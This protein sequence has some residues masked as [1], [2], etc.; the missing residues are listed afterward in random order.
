MVSQRQF[1]A[2]FVYLFVLA[3]GLFLYQYAFFA[4]TVQANPA[5]VIIFLLY[6][7]GPLVYFLLGAFRRYF[8]WFFYKKHDV[9]VEVKN[10]ML[11]Y[12]T[13]LVLTV[14]TQQVLNH[15]LF[16]ITLALIVPLGAALAAFLVELVLYIQEEEEHKYH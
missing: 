13:F 3:I 2:V 5:G 4:D 14:L 9:V 16:M 11:I 15:A 10:M 12:V 8:H 7:G 6:L 1:V